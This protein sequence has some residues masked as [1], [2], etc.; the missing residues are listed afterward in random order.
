MGN[1]L[2]LEERRYSVYKHTTPSGKVYIG[3]TS[4]KPQDRWAAGYKC[5]RAFNAAIQKYGWNNITSEIL[6][7]DM[8]REDACSKEI[9]LIAY[10]N[11]TDSQY[12]YNIS[13]GG[14][15]TLLGLPVSQETRKKLSEISRKTWQDKEYRD[16]HSG[17][18]AYWSGKHHTEESLQKIKDHHADQRGEN[19]P[20]Y[21]KRHTVESK[22]RMSKA[23]I[24]KY[25]RSK[26]A[27][28]KPVLQLTLDGEY[29]TN[30][31][32]MEDAAEATK[33]H[34]SNIRKVIKGERKQAGGF[35]WQYEEAY[36]NV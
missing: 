29:I 1:C 2:H 33:T 11:S 5:C 18:N 14:S 3:I 22:E 27:H 35:K 23:K 32:C 36:N 8:N 24:G 15:T 12:G 31:L 13:K 25:R 10:Y 17:K 6:F 20:M 16:A 28:A 7:S 21:G 34:S 9:E 4:M 30:Y 26:S 19:H